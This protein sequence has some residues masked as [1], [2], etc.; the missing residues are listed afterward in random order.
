MTVFSREL[1]ISFIGPVGDTDYKDVETGVRLSLPESTELSQFEFTA[2]YAFMDY[3]VA[4]PQ[5]REMT[6]MEKLYKPFK[7]NMWLC[8]ILFVSMCAVFIISML[9]EAPKYAR[10]FVFGTKATTP[11]WNLTSLL[12]NGSIASGGQIPSRNF[13]RFMLTL[14]LIFAVVIHNSYRGL[15]FIFFSADIRITPADSLDD[16]FDKNFTISFI[17]ETFSNKFSHIRNFENIKRVP[18][19]SGRQEVRRKLLLSD[20]D[21]EFRGAWLYSYDHLLHTNVL[22]NQEKQAIIDYFN[23]EPES[24]SLNF[25][26]EPIFTYPRFFVIKK[27]SLLVD[28]FSKI[29][30]ELLEHGFIDHW[31]E[32]YPPDPLLVKPARQRPTPLALHNILG[33]SNILI[34]GWSLAFIVFILEYFLR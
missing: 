8:I 22:L 33:I 18:N 9:F 26:S 34:G 13:A 21:P 7:S 16:F 25:I 6:L 30:E 1:N 3:V 11:L 15:L 12:L 20:P 32:M 24:A 28:K 19:S 14:I 31:M 29:I 5:G 23:F 27:N 2:F 10:Q 4:I 17:N